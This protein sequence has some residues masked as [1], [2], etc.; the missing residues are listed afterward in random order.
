MHATLKGRSAEEAKALY[1]KNKRH[2]KKKEKR[3][4][5]Q[6]WLTSLS[7]MQHVMKW[8]LYGSTLFTAKPANANAYGV[9][10]D[11]CIAVNQEGVYVLARR[12]IPS[13]P[14]PPLP[15][16]SP[17]YSPSPSTL[18]LIPFQ[19]HQAD[20]RFLRLPK[21]HRDGPHQQLVWHHVTCGW[22]EQS[23]K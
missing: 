11:L 1:P 9:H 13:Y 4:L 12:Y 23:Y 20:P 15:L 17:S 6:I 22:R 5:C 10:T 14:S 18:L 8:P 16:P 19:K 21:H 3:A 2:E 7:Y